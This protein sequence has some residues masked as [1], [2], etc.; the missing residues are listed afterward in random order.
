MIFFN[1]FKSFTITIL[2]TC[3]IVMCMTTKLE[4]LI[5]EPKKEFANSVKYWLL[6]NPIYKT[7]EF[8]K[9]TSQI[10]CSQLT[11]YDKYIVTLF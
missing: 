1:V 11:V 4:Y 5:G 10:W 3:K 8:F 7:F 9:Q 6:R 2:T